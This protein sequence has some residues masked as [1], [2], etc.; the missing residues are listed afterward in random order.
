MI[1][2]VKASRTALGES[3]CVEVLVTVENPSSTMQTFNITARVSNSTYLAEVNLTPLSAT[4]SSGNSTTL[5]FSW[6]T[7]GLA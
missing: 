2:G 6:N 3:Q 5:G 4:L 1:T 7:T